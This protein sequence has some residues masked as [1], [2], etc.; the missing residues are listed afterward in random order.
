[1]ELTAIL[2]D[3][4]RLGT[5]RVVGGRPPDPAFEAL[6]IGGGRRPRRGQEHGAHQSQAARDRLPKNILGDAI[7]QLLRFFALQGGLDRQ[8]F[9][10]A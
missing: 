8:A 5:T 3:A 9:K 2:A 7:V 6:R 4:H 1:V 10:P